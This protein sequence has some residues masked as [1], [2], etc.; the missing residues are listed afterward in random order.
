MRCGVCKIWVTIFKCSHLIVKI[1]CMQRFIYVS[2]GIYIC[3]DETVQD[4]FRRI[5]TIF[6]NWISRE[7]REFNSCFFPCWLDS[8]CR[9]RTILSIVLFC[10]LIRFRLIPAAFAIG[11]KYVWIVAAVYPFGSFFKSSRYD[12]RTSSEIS[13]ILLMLFSFAQFAKHVAD[14]L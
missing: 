3:E 7:K 6:W 1:I 4:S 11:A 13:E 14:R 2:F 9:P 5:P 8:S 12:Y 10:F